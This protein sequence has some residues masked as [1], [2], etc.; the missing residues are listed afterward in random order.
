MRQRDAN[1]I[2]QA[3]LAFRPS[4]TPRPTGTSRTESYSADTILP[5][6]A[7][8]VNSFCRFSTTFCRLPGLFSKAT[9]KT[10]KILQKVIKKLLTNE[11]NGV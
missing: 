5:Q 8:T 6:V 4:A 11:K 2:P 10:S 7:V 1:P 3:L 9:I